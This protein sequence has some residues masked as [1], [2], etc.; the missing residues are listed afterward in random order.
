MNFRA[1][2][3]ICFANARAPS[4]SFDGLLFFLRARVLSLVGTIR[5]VTLVALIAALGAA[6]AWT[7]TCDTTKT[8]G[9]DYT[10]ING[11]I[12]AIPL[13]LTGNFCIMIQGGN[14]SEEVRITSRT[15]NNFR[16]LISSASGATVNINPPAGKTAGLWISNTSVTIQ[17][18]NVIPANTLSYGVYVT[19]QQ[20]T[21]SSVNVIDPS[22][23][24]TIA[25]MQL[26]SWN[27]VS[28]SSVS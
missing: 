6:H 9:V 5:T 21:I 13:S 20:V 12:G 23:K 24:I 2:E 22:G 27:T 25:G 11:A 15:S 7:A 8:V 19:S 16:I 17:G 26:A 1:R 4:V 14:Y 10:T 18:I 28:Y 3:F